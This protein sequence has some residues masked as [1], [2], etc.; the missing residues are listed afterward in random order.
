[1]EKLIVATK[2]EHT[3]KV[4]ITD[5]YVYTQQRN[6]VDLFFLGGGRRGEGLGKTYENFWHL[7][8]TIL[9]YYND[10][11]NKGQSTV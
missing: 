6:R 2:N 7:G 3:E 5:I 11:D 1:M 10:L 9:I 4:R 8:C